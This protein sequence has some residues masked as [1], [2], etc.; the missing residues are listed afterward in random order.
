MNRVIHRAVFLQDTSSTI[1]YKNI[2][3]GKIEEFKIFSGLKG[4]LFSTETLEKFIEEEIRHDDFSL[5]SNKKRSIQTFS[6]GEQRKA[7]LHYL[8]DKKPDFLVLSGIFDMIDAQSKI[9]LQTEIQKVAQTI[10]I[11]QIV[12]R[13]DN[14]LPF[15]KYALLIHNRKT[16]YKGSAHDF[17]STIRDKNVLNTEVRLPRAIDGQKQFDNPLVQFINT[18]V[19]YSGKTIVKNINWTINHGDFWQLKGSN[20]AGK[21][22]LLSMITGDNPKAYGQHLIL[23]GKK[24][25][26]GESI[27]EIKK[28]IG[29]VTPAMT[30]HFRGWNTAE[31]MVISGLTDSIGLYKKP[32]ELQRNLADQWLDLIGLKEKKHTRFSNLTET[33][34]CM[35]L[36]ARAMIK[37]PPLLILDEPTHGLN[38]KGAL[39]L[40]ALVNK[41]AEDGKTTVVFV[42]HRKEPGLK[43]KQVF[44][45]VPGSCGSLGKEINTQ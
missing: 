25:G 31:K 30:S 29:Y 42:S 11:V 4:A 6:S 5:S 3:E 41:I 17:L 36:I 14:L 40:S 18:E 12:K 9:Q 45:L 13:S 24:R 1:L 32:T 21:T 15:I 7:L 34:Q 28:K 38:D 22:T 16:L 43:P 10:S 26:T 23:F 39:L 20:G 27:W 33:Q 44:E 2:T 8:L 37:H 35:V 19:K